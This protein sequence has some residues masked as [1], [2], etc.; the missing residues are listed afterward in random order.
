MTPTEAFNANPVLFVAKIAVIIGALNWL[1][2]GLQNT[3]YLSMYFGTNAKFIYILA[4]VAG[5]YLAYLEITMYTR[6]ENLTVDEILQNYGRD[7][8]KR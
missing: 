8:Q 2:I 3:N 7:E 4:G 6:K 1:A 5:A